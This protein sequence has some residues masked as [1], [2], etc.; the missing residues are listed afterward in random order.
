MPDI[1]R[2]GL[3]V[4]GTMLVSGVLCKLLTIEWFVPMS[5]LALVA[6][7]A[8]VSFWDIRLCKNC[9]E[10]IRHIGGDKTLFVHSFLDERRCVGKSTMAE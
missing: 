9:G 3:C 2:V 6:F 7:A 1:Y 10:L 5:A 4:S 8:K